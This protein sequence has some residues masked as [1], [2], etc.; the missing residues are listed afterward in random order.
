MHDLEV[1]ADRLLAQATQDPEYP[2]RTERQMWR[3]RARGRRREAPLRPWMAAGAATPEERT[4]A[5]MDQQL[6]LQSAELTSEERCCL[7]LYV[8]YDLSDDEIGDLLGKHRN[9]VRERRGV[10]YRK[11]RQVVSETAEMVGSAR[12][13]ESGGRASLDGAN[14]GSGEVRKSSCATNALSAPIGWD[15][16]IC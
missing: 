13:Q 6:V 11:V 10:A 7:L 4:M 3:R 12:A 2:F 15:A 8:Q 14:S 5:V 9:T 16:R 1:E